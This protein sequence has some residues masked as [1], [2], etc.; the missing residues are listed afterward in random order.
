M[1]FVLSP[2]RILDFDAENRP[3]SYLGDW[4]TAE[5]TVIAYKFLPRDSIVCLWQPEFTV[6][7]ILEDFV[8]AYDDADI[9]TGHNIRKHDLP[10]VNA[11]LLEH[12]MPPLRPIL[13]SDTYADLK[14][15]SPGFGSQKTLA[16]MLGV[17]AP[18]VGMSTK[19]WRGANRFEDEAVQ[20][21]LKRCIG[22]VK[23]HV[24]LRAR[25]LE[26]GWLRAPRRWTP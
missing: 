4:T 8:T 6:Q 3:L 19:G 1:P 18:K 23:Q 22:D 11:A 10:M 16:A 20:R 5:I 14:R 15:R 25:L 2:Q 13:V 24:Q 21:A 26:L 12:K 7:A 17:S 9:V